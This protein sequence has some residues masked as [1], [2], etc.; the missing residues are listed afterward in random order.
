L[1]SLLARAA[2]AV[3]GASLLLLAVAPNA[4]QGVVSAAKAPD[5]AVV[6]RAHAAFAKYMSDHA[7]AVTAGKW[8]SPGLQHNGAATGSS[9][10]VTALPSVNWSGY[11]DVESS[12]SQTFSNVSG[13]WIL[14]A[15]RCLPHPYQ[16][17]DA[18]L[19]Q[20]VGIDG[21]TNSTVEQLGTGAQCYEGVLYY[22]VWY[23]MFPNGMVEEGLPSCINDNVNCAQPGDQISASVTVT[24]GAAGENNYTL[25]LHDYTTPGNNFSVTQS[26]ATN[27]C[28]DASAEWIVERPAFSLPF[29]F[30]ILPLVDFHRTVFEQ[31][32]EVSGGQRSSIAGFQGGPVYDVQMTDDSGAYYLDCIGQQAPPGTLLSISPNQCATVSPFR[33]GGFVTTWDSSF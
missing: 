10:T 11:A 31:G 4:Q 8:V 14:P 6:A 12:T 33:N 15:V 26:C 25:S 28:L 1:K 17:Q 9:G 3:F 27:T 16:N 22:Y 18:F 19:A 20:W 23:E 7:N 32:S 21:A 5:A 30:Q 29:G 13:R 24:P 2:A